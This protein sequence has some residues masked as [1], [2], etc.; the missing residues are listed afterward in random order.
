VKQTEE[1]QILLPQSLDSGCDC[2][3][4]ER[5]GNATAKPDTDPGSGKEKWSEPGSGKKRSL[6]PALE[7]KVV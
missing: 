4:P 1:S 7:K 3:D 5:R 6:T 2:V